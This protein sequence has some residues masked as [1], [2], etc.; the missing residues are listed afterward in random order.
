M[1]S[2]FKH[3]RIWHAKN[4]LVIVHKFWDLGW[5]PILGKGEWG[6]GS[7]I[8]KKSQIMLFFWALLL[9]KCSK[10][11]KS[12]NT[13][14]DLLFISLESVAA[15]PFSKAAYQDKGGTS[16]REWTNDIKTQQDRSRPSTVAENWKKRD[17]EAALV[18][19]AAHERWNKKAQRNK[20]IW[21]R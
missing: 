2:M 7:A 6:V 8:W 3:P 13:F 18:Q 17:L 15:Y 10:D 16:E 19:N 11:K 21:C 9:S 4:D 1:E 14:S 20:Q 5:L 12:I